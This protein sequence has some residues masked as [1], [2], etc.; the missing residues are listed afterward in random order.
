MKCVGVYE[1]TAIRTSSSCSVITLDTIREA[2]QRIEPHVRSTPVFTS[3]YFDTLFGARLFFKCENLQRFGAFKPRG[4]VN[5]VLSLDAQTARH[6]VATH[7]S[8]NHAVALA[9][10][11]ALRGIDCTIV[12][13]HTVPDVKKRA[14]EAQGARVVFC[15]PTLAARE[16]MLVEIVAETGAH[17]VHPS[18]DLR[19]IAGQGTAA[20]ELMTE[21]PDLDVI[22]APVGG[23]GLMSGTAIVARALRPLIDI[24]G[25][26]PAI[27]DDAMRSIEAGTIIKSADPNTIA[28]G[29]R[30]S[31]GDHTFE[32]LTRTG[33]RII[34][35]SEESIIE[36]LYLVMEHMKLVVEP[37]ATVSI[38][39][40]LE[41]PQLLNNK[42]IGV[43]FCGGNLDIRRYM[44]L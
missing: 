43:I 9:Y 14:V 22:M 31:L 27:A 20:L 36:G 4:A 37:S 17:V 38:G 32:I 28:D 1:A 12:M 44:Q 2:A 16:A 5:A 15:E 34:T 30:T 26:E 6:G 13:P 33:V 39:A 18:N 11:A 35:A 25:V 8:G 3:D 29:L 40:L 19:V 24:I 10:A 21:V 7:S 42:R 23:G 41:R